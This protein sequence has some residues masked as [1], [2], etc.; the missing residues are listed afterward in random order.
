MKIWKPITFGRAEKILIMALIGLT[1]VVI[2]IGTIPPIAA[3]YVHL[4][5]TWS[6]LAIRYGYVGAF[7]AALIGNLTVIIVFPYTIA[8][9]FLATQGLDPFVLGVLTGVGAWLG[10]LSGYLIGRL[11][12]NRFRT[13]KPTE[14]EALEKIVRYRPR[15]VQWLLFL[16]SAL[17]LP[18]DVLFIPLG[19]LRY[20]LWSLFWPSVLGKT[21]AG[22]AI[23][24]FGSFSGSIVGSNDP[25]SW[26]SMLAELGSLYTLSI[27]MYA[28]VKVDWNAFMHRLLDHPDVPT[29]PP[30]AGT[31]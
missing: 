5:D 9:F 6:E 7:L 28:M 20:P 10:E 22:L 13:A 29:E 1:V 4:N 31:A 11:G 25:T 8:T 14:F 18:D 26:S 17:P 23:T 12:T 30:H 21:A 2:A 24:Y 3:A 15:F 16:F 19:I 27:A